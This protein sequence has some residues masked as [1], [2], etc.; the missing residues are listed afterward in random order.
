MTSSTHTIDD[1]KVAEVADFVEA[2][3]RR[4]RWK[5]VRASRTRY[6]VNGDYLKLPV[7]MQIN[8]AWEKSKRLQMIE[9]EWND[10][11][12]RRY[13]RLT[14]IPANVPLDA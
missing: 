3:G 8:D 14:I 7:E 9:D 4:K 5:G 11:T 13:P 6:Y 12:R 1:T 2:Y 10:R